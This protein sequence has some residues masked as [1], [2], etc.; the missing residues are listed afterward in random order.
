MHASL[1]ALWLP[2][3]CALNMSRPHLALACAV[4][5]DS[6]LFEALL[7]GGSSSAGAPTAVEPVHVRSI[8][9]LPCYVCHPLLAACV[10]QDPTP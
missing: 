5:A 7:H 1:Q 10:M 6:R 2:Q 8:T 4:R 9:R 3:F